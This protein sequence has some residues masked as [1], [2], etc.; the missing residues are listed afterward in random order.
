MFTVVGP[1]RRGRMPPTTEFIRV[2]PRN[3][4]LSAFR[5]HKGPGW[6]LRVVENQG[7][8]ADATIELD[9]PFGQAVETDLLGRKVAKVSRDRHG[10]PF[11]IK[12][13]KIRTFRIMP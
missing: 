7:Q 8:E 1:P 10:L 9:F 6:E 11:R 3:V 5:K 4:Q 13:W 12:P 2:N